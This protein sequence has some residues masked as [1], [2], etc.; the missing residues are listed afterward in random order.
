MLMDD[1]ASISQVRLGVCPHVDRNDQ[2]CGTRFSI[3][4]LEQAFSVCFGTFYGCPMY[5]RLNAE[6][7][8]AEPPQVA[9]E[10]APML[11]AARYP[12]VITVAGHALETPLRPTGS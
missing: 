11:S 5:H 1:A 2:R 10:V 8:Q 4:R 3:G 9:P 6:L 7:A 12:V